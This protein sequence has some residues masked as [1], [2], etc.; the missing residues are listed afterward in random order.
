MNYETLKKY[1]RLHRDGFPD[2]LA[3]RCHRALSWLER[4]EGEREDPDAQFIFLWISFNAAYAQQVDRKSAQHEQQRFQ[5]FFEKICTLD[6]ERRLYGLI[7]QRYSTDIRLLLDNRYLYGPF[8][9][10]HNGDEEAADWEDRFRRHKQAAHLALG[11]GDVP[12]LLSVVF[13][14]LYTLR[15]QLVHGGATW[16]SSVNR[17]Q[18]RLGASILGYVVPTVIELMMHNPRVLWGDGCYPVVGKG[19]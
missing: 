13:S 3:L 11:K 8:W 2:G 9:D 4:A 15:N 16:Q 6:T 18:V 10:F 5:L 7:W 19:T 17:A 12:T 14:S 1:Q